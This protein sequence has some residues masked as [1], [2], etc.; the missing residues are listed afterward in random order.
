MA[1]NGEISEVKVSQEALDIAKKQATLGYRI[2]RNKA[3]YFMLAPYFILFFLFTVIPV[4]LSVCFS[5]TYYNML[6][7]P[8]FIGWKNYIKLFLEDDIFM[9][10]LKNTMILAVVTGPVSYFLCLLFAWIINEFKGW[11]RAFLTL[12]FYAPSICG[13]A[14]VV[15]TLILSGWYSGRSDS[16]DED[17]K[18]RASVPDSRTALAEFGNRLP[19]LYRRSAD[20]RQIL[21]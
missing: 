13:N 18:I 20:G 10:A 19:V 17:G 15:W 7:M 16:V 1:G 21:V 8:E 5:F 3:C 12:I 2:K 4:I 11:V 14:Y 9:K 6:E